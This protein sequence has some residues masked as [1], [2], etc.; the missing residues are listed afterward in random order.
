MAAFVSRYAHAFAD[1]VT[2]QKLD[3]E[4]LDRIL[5]DF[6]K[7]WEGSGELRGFYV[8]PAIAVAEK[9]QFLDQLN[10]KLGMPKEMRNLIAVLIRNDRVGMVVDVI[11]A[12][13]AELKARQGIRQAEIVTA[14]ALGEAERSELAAGVEKLAGSRIEANFKLDASILGG[15]VVRIGST[16]YD[17][18]VRGRLERL[19]EALI[20]G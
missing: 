5:D 1:V 9:I 3:V 16:V 17:G 18:S 11:A 8:N 12:Y 6:L 10:K 13:R 4:A 2:Q 15:A 20:A 19:K 14:R 7:T